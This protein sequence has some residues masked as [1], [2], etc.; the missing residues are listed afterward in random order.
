MA[1]SPFAVDRASRAGRMP[2][3]RSVS[4]LLALLAAHGA[5]A[6]EP[7]RVQFVNGDVTLQRPDGSRVPVRK[8][9]VI[10]GGD[11]LITGPGA[12]AQVRA[13]DQGVVALR[14]D[15]A[16]TFSPKA[17]GLGITLDQGQLR[18]VTMPG[19]TAPA[20]L[21]IT[22]PDSRM[23]LTQGDLETGLQPQDG[24]PETL[25]QLRAG[26][27]EVEGTVIDPSSVAPGQVFRTEGGL[28]VAVA[29]AP[30]HAPVTP[31]T[32][33]LP[34]TEGAA[35]P[36]N[37]A[38]PALPLPEVRALPVQP[39]ATLAGLN[40]APPGAGLPPRLGAEPK[41][42]VP[43]V[44]INV[45]TPTIAGASTEINNGLASL[46]FFAAGRIDS[47]DRALTPT[48]ADALPAGTP[49]RTI[50][51][52]PTTV[53]GAGNLDIPAVKVPTGAAVVVGQATPINTL[54]LVAQPPVVPAPGAL[55]PGVPAKA[56]TPDQIVNAKTLTSGGVLQPTLKT[57]TGTLKFN[58]LR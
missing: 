50:A 54:V 31:P 35:L 44:R 52:E 13:Q 41:V 40:P 5:G 57:F 49:T 30:L 16:I 7:L 26:R 46:P 15:S 51:L 14:P 22:T 6:A 11:R 4:L 43:E 36:E 9:D 28:P 27:I 29:A 3:R 33:G 1:R 34:G 24:T 47:I 45:V 10:G 17:Q 48:T 2:L 55:T 32:P 21:Q 20:P 25:N 19:L 18:A 42:A 8:G 23:A 58:G 53:K 38:Q 56:I 37:G 12:V 39:L